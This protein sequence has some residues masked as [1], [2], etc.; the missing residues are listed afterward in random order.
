MSCG[1]LEIS[2]DN[3]DD[4]GAFLLLYR[5]LAKVSSHV[6]F[7]VPKCSKN[8]QGSIRQTL[9]N[10]IMFTIVPLTKGS[11]MVKSKIQVGRNYPS[12][13]ILKG[14]L[15]KLFLQWYN[16][17]AQLKMQLTFE[18]RYS[19]K[20]W[21]WRPKMWAKPAFHL[22]IQHFT[23]FIQL[24]VDVPAMNL[25]KEV[26]LSQIQQETTIYILINNIYIAK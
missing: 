2:W 21:S 4:L 10:S 12:V 15:L 9:F 16:S 13:L 19:R 6:R 1:F 22:I 11:H 26:F 3:R 23:F 18:Y 25:M 24:S 14:E 7:R 8:G 17:Y 5:R 20:K